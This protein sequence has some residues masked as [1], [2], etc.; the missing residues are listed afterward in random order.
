LEGSSDTSA[1][2]I[3]ADTSCRLLVEIYSG[4]H[5]LWSERFQPIQLIGARRI[6][7][8]ATWDDGHIA[9]NI[10]GHDLSP[11]PNAALDA[12]VLEH[13]PP[14]N[15]PPELRLYAHVSP[16]EARNPLDAFFLETVTDI[17]RRMVVCT[18]YELIR[19][20]GLLRQLFLD[21]IP[22]L[23][24]VNR[25]YRVKICFEVRPSR[26]GETLPDAPATDIDWQGLD[27]APFPKKRAE[28][29]NLKGLLAT[30]I[31]RMGTSCFTVRDLIKVYANVQ[32]GVHWTTASSDVERA[33][34]KLEERASAYSGHA[35]AVNSL[36]DLCRVAL[37]GVGPLV[38]AIRH[39]GHEMA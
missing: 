26:V 24:R 25:E 28:L 21:D 17:D 20:T 38:R 7:I 32:G 30:P 4:G 5:V 12:F 33:F 29:V 2:Q 13:S 1:A 37:R 19:A 9:L 23:H 15:L 3:T 35:A 27:P 14:D 10:D 31:A 6:A 16:A 36:A 11:D 8:G 34:L 22:L 18:H 39:R